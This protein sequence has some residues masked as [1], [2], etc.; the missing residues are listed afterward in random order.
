MYICMYVCTHKTYRYVV[1]GGWGLCVC[2]CTNR[3]SNL[4][5]S[6]FRGRYTYSFLSLITGEVRPSNGPGRTH[7]LQ[8]KLGWEFHSL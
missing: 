1:G 5:L 4:G 2:T 6:L 3:V 8:L 7:H